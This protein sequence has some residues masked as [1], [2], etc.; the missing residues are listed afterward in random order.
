MRLNGKGQVTIPADLRAQ[1]GLRPGDEVE[2]VDDDGVLRIVRVDNAPTAGR[3]MV[4]RMRGQATTKMTTDELM[5]L[6]RAE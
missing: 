4:A 6:V 3:R 2:V 1:H 5:A